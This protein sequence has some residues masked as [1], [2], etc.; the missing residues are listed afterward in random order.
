MPRGF[1]NT[2]EYPFLAMS[3]TDE[4]PP[5]REQTVTGVA[6]NARI[7]FY[8]RNSICVFETQYQVIIQ[9]TWYC[10]VCNSRWPSADKHRNWAVN[11]IPYL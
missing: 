1:K 5:G 10:S 11:L 3:S 8:H 7:A 2:F 9:V 6:Y 4:A